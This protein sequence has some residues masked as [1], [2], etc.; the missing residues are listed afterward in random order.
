MP[1]EGVPAATPSQVASKAALLHR[2][3]LD[4]TR[5]IEGVLSGAY[6]AYGRGPGSERVGARRYEPGDDA[7]RI[8][9][10]LTARTMHPHVHVTEPDRELETWFVADQ[11]ASLDFGTAERE[12]RELVLAAVAT[13]GFMA[14]RSGNRFGLLTAG[15]AVI[16]RVPARTGR[17]AVLAAL[18]WLYD[19]PRHESAPAP[20]ADLAAALTQLQ[21]THRRRGRVGVA[22]DFLDAGDWRTPLAHLAL[23]HDVVAV[24]VVDRREL[25]LPD[26]GMLRVVDPETGR[27][28][29]VQT[30]SRALR[31]RFAAAATER[32]DAIRAD[33]A[34]AGAACF[35][36][37]TDGDWVLDVLRFL[38]TRT[39]F[40][41]TYA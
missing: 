41:R 35:E 18:S 34:G 24:H 26:V 30:R 28:L 17:L 6:V 31:D 3:E 22:S 40:A 7:R 19:A 36:L 20:G 27:L 15:G 32:R 29:E 10:N 25:E 13:F 39:T 37:R 5:R 1:A 21:R 9:W 23:H 4:V 16:G 38:T 12:K 11:S 2:L 33:I 8:D 14:A